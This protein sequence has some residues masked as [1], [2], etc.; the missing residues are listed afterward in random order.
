M[1]L[2]DEFHWDRTKQNKWNFQTRRFCGLS[3]SG[4][5][6]NRRTGGGKHLADSTG[7]DH[8]AFDMFMRMPKA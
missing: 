8:A 7:L 5:N 2:P 3:C 6:S 1:E 4:K